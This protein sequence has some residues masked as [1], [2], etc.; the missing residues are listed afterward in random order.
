MAS[1]LMG[2]YEMTPFMMPSTSTPGA[3][4]RYLA[5]FSS[6]DTALSVAVS[7]ASLR[8]FGACTSSR[9]GAQ[10]VT[11]VRGDLSEG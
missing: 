3:P 8:A 11:S 6:D 1:P 4:A 10:T 2:R 7:F 9:I 5:I